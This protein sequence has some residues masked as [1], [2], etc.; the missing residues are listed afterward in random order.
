[1]VHWPGSPEVTI[2]RHEKPRPGGVVVRTSVLTM[3]SHTGTHIDAPVHFSA[4]PTGVDQLPL[5][6]LIGVARVVSIQDPTAVRRA[7]IEPLGIRPGERI[8]F[9]TRN[10]TRCWADEAFAPDYV[11]V[12]LEAAR[13]LAEQRV[14]TVGVDY[15]SVASREE[16]VP[17]HR[18]LLEA[19]IA[20]IEGL[21]L[22]RVE[23][24]EFD[25]IALPLRI[26]AGDGAPARVV[27]RRRT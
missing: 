1:M 14:L 22:S 27:L 21:D 23:P 17:I 12:S 11:Y 4:G 13:Y 19:R 3:D 6:A 18:A 24:G 20:V 5:E 8:L 16:S 10:S 25:L 7:E 2:E 9:K 15:L 26:E